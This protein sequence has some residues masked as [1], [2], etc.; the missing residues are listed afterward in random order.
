MSD[1]GS[2]AC[3]VENPPLPGSEA[4]EGFRNYYLRNTGGGYQGVLTEDDIARSRWTPTQF[5]LG[6]AGAT[7]DLQHIVLS[8]C[9]ALVPTATEVPGSGGECDPDEQNLYEKSGAELRLINVTPGAE[10]AAQSR[11]ISSDGSRVYWTDGANLHLRDG[12]VDKQVDTTVGG[13][14]TFETA[15]ADGSIAYFSK[16]GHLYRYR[17]SGEACRR[18]DSGGGSSRGCSAPPR[19]GPTS[20]T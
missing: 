6:F 14:G 10:L 11:A 3:P 16:A 4:P 17:T 19:T 2:S 9:A 1:L 8:T 18:P 15:S 20:T 13:G 7:P 12:A 5:E